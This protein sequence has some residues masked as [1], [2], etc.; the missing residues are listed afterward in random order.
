MEVSAFAFQQA[1]KSIIASQIYNNPTICLKRLITLYSHY[2]KQFVS[3]INI[4][5]EPNM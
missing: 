5:I 4:F 3:K 1:E 2:L